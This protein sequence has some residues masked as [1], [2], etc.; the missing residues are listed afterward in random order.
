VAAP[1]VPGLRS[2]LLDIARDPEGRKTFIA[3]QAKAEN[4]A[5]GRGGVAPENYAAPA[6]EAEDTEATQGQ[7]FNVLGQKPKQYARGTRF[8]PRTGPAIVHRGEAI[9]PRRRAAIMRR[10]PSAFFGE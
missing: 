7:N 1:R 10:K 2:A 5:E 9:I 4:Q 8:V 6:K 3:Q